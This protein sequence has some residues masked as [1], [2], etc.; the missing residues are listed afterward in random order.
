MSRSSPYVVVLSDVDRAEL[1]RRAG[2]Y[3]LPHAEVVRAKIVLLAADGMRELTVRSLQHRAAAIGKP[4][5]EEAARLLAAQIDNSALN[6]RLASRS[7]ESSLD[8]R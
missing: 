8:Q 3:T 4:G 7:R 5:D 6:R 1:V 2:S